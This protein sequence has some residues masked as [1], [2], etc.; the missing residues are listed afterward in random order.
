[1]PATIR[2]LLE[3]T[4]LGPPMELL[5]EPSDPSEVQLMEELAAGRVPRV[6]RDAIEAKGDIIWPE[7]RERAQ[8]VAATWLENQ[9]RDRLRRLKE[10]LPQ[11]H[12]KPQ[13]PV[14]PVAPPPSGAIVV[15]ELRGQVVCRA[16]RRHHADHCP[17]TVTLIEASALSL[18]S[19]DELYHD[20]KPTGMPIDLTGDRRFQAP[21]LGPCY[22]LGPARLVEIEETPAG[23]GMLPGDDV[24]INRIRSKVVHND[25]RPYAW[26]LP[27]DVTMWTRLFATGQRERQPATKEEVYQA[28]RRQ[29]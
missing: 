26:Y 11:D 9:R 27:D 8:E 13:P 1:M 29:A 10:K 6:L 16:L 12:R 3:G 7:N 20:S 21:Y 18:L 22:V 14:L 28:A 15:A 4:R 2:E 17:Q 24:L 25:W 5:A 23:G 19:A